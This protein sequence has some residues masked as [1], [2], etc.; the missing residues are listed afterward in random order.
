MDYL[1]RIRSTGSEANPFFG[2]MGIEVESL[3]EGVAVLR[4]E[5]RGDM[6]NGEGWLQGGVFTA[7]ADEAMVLAI[8]S[9]LEPGERI[10]TITETTS[11]L[12]GSQEA[13]LY[14]AGRVIKRGRRVVFAE[15]EVRT[16]EPERHL[17]SRSSAAF[18]VRKDR[19][20]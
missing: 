7:L 13:T 19:K 12:A 2:L 15:A 8:Y 9:L 11:F 6:M 1:E 20:P 17:L 14:A 3:G 16:G 10:A 18:A 5:A 4:M